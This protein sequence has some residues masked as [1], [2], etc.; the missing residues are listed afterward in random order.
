M[1]ARSL[2]QV[3][4]GAVDTVLQIACPAVGALTGLSLFVQLGTRWP[5]LFKP[6][7]RIEFDGQTLPLIAVLWLASAAAGAM[8]FTLVLSAA[9][10]PAGR[11]RPGRRPHQGTLRR[12]TLITGILSLTRIFGE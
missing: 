2:F 6:L 1:F 10:A 8:V 7:E 11:G 12:C 5:G 4:M 9:K 3:A